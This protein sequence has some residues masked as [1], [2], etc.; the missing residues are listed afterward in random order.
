MALQLPTPWSISPTIIIIRKAF[1]PIITHPLDPL[2][3]NTQPF[4]IHD[5]TFVLQNMVSEGML[6]PVKNLKRG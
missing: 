2:D 3:F 1:C 4:A 5:E 6:K